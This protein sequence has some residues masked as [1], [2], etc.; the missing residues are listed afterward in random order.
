MNF[1]E[2][3]G[4]DHI[5][6]HLITTTD[7]GRISHAQLFVGKEGSGTL[8]LAIAY[9][10][11]VLCGKD[12]ACYFK[13]GAFSHPDLHFIYPTITTK[14]IKKPKSTDFLVDWRKFLS[15]NPYG[16]LFDWQNKIG[17]LNKNCEIRVEDAQ[18]VLKT[19]SLK[20]FEGGYKILIV[21]QADKM[22]NACANKLLKIIEEPPQK[23]LIILITENIKTILQTI[24]SRCQTINIRSLDEETIAKK[25]IDNY[26]INEDIAKKIAYQ[27]QGNLNKVMEIMQNKN[28]FYFNKW[29][30]KLNRNA[31]RSK[32]NPS[33]ITEHLKWVEEIAKEGKETQKK[34]FYYCIDTF[35]QALLLNYQVKSL[36]YIKPDEK[37]FSDDK[38]TLQS[39]SPYVNGTNIHGIFKELSDAIYHIERN[40]NVKL[41]LTDLS[42]KLTRLIHQK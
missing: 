14:D 26:S 17:D 40:G 4:Q 38:F 13:Y 41:I 21:W 20:S 15:E 10:Y 28:E 36:V 30:V 29:F 12:S 25:L 2:V 35:R 7:S 5:K 23:T 9:A 16:N 11:Y 33:I 18:N 6:N 31:F 1:E 42:M 24:K 39:F 3:L 8:P 22:N 32:K 19:L 34:F 27:S 37:N